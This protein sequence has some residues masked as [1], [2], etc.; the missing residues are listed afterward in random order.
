MI[1]NTNGVKNALKQNKKA[2]E[3]F[4]ELNK[5]SKLQKTENKVR[6]QEQMILLAQDAIE[7]NEINNDSKYY[8]Y[9][10]KYSKAQ[11]VF[12]NNGKK[13]YVKLGEI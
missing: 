1:S 6:T 8:E 11:V 5:L 7:N 4:W 13:L 10:L 2:I 9:V 12:N 3:I